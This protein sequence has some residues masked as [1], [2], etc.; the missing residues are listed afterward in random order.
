MPGTDLAN[1]D[2]SQ[3]PSTQVG[4]DAMYDDLAKSNE[5]LGRFQLFTKGKAID[6]GLITPGHYGIPESADEI[7]GLGD[8][9]DILVLARRPKALDMTDK[10]AII[11][12]YNNESAEFKRIAAQ[13]QEKESNCMYGPSFLIYERTTGRFLEF[14]CGSK[15][16][17]S[18][19]KK[20]YPF[21]PLTAEDIKARGLTDQ[22]PHGP[23]PMTLKSKYVEKGSYS[24]H[25]PVVVKCSVPFT[26]GPTNEK[27]IAEIIKFIS[28]KEDGVE[29]VVEDA[30][31]AK[32]GAKKR[33]R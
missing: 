21:L 22:E 15:S 29:R 10:E 6:R 17:R 2:L 9:V 5:F 26:K 25:V 18:E 4:N 12:S 27:L 28:P 24:W 3:L 31:A 7:T 32:P 30:P 14:F 8:S 23:L 13:S 20:I 33:A 19:S 16:T 11:V 1:L